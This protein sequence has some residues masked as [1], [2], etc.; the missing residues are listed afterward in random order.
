[1]RS[2]PAALNLGAP[3][4]IKGQAPLLL[5]IDCSTSACTAALF[6]PDGALLAQRDE[7]IGRGHAER[8]VPMIDELLAGRTPT[9]IL[10]GT[11]PGSFT[12]LR[13][14]IA[15]AHGLAIGWGAALHGMPSLALLAASAPGEEPVVATMAGGHG[16][17]F[18]QSFDRSPFAATSA[19]LN[20][21][22]CDAAAAF[23][24]GTPV[25]SGATTLAEARGETAP[26]T[27]VPTASA[28]L[29]LPPALR[30]LAPAPLYVR[31][32]DAQPRAA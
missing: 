17:L 30:T 6:T 10:V 3:V 25:G 32:P 20:L 12:G 5:A 1:M 27:L 18:V 19:A 13:V 14:A 9:E 4:T 23:P 15:A 24:A 28:A 16:E 8:L 22:P 11:G 26:A 21:A 29:R 2:G 31:A 7:L